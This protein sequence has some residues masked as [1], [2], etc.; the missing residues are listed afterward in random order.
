MKSNDDKCHL[1]VGTNS[2][3]NIKKGSVNLTNSN[4][5]KLFGLKFEHKLTFDERPS[6]PWKRW[7]KHSCTSKGIITYE[8]LKKRILMNAFLRSQFSDCPLV[9]MCYGRADYSKTNRTQENCFRIIHSYKQSSHETFL[10][11]DSSASIHNIK[12]FLCLGPKIHQ[13][14]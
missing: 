11:K 3:V 10:E 9:W 7:Q 6:E 8:F 4:F 5:E 14:G 13:I 2:T 12:D 1:I